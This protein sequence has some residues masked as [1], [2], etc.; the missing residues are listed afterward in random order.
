MRNDKLR[1]R[2]LEADNSSLTEVMGL[3]AF[4]GLETFCVYLSRV[5]LLV[6][7]CMHRAGA[8]EAALRSGYNLVEGC[9]E[10]TFG[11]GIG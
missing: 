6:P 4:T 8:E 3:H 2:V 5:Y 7:T 1:R 10:V 9:E 11:L